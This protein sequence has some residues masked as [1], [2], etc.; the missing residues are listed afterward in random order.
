MI[1]RGG[2]WKRKRHLDLG[3]IVRNKSPELVAKFLRR[4]HDF[5]SVRIQ[6]IPINLFVT[7]KPGELPFGQP[8]GIPFHQR[9]RLRER[10]RT[11]KNEP[12]VTVA[13]AFHGLEV[14]TVSVGDEAAYLIEQTAVDHLLAVQVE[15]IVELH[16]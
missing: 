10:H 6:M 7:S 15:L 5:A 8:P 9:Q 13:D 16:S 4:R 11:L 14:V 2:G 12:H 3:G 1:E